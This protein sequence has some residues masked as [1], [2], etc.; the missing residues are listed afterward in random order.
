ML[1]DIDTLSIVL[2]ESF[3]I[4]SFLLAFVFFKKSR[5]IRDKQELLKKTLEKATV[6]DVW[7][8]CYSY[9]WVMSHTLKPRKL[10]EA[11]PFLAIGVFFLTALLFFIFI[12]LLSIGYLALVA[13]I[14]I[15]ILFETDAFEA[16]S[17]SRSLQKAPLDHLKGEDQSY[18]ELAKEALEN[19]IIRFLIIGIIFAIAGPFIP[20]IFDGLIYAFVAYTR[21]MFQTTE[22][23]KWISALALVVALILTGVLLFLPEFAGRIIFR[24]VKL[25]AQRIQ[26][27]WGKR[28]S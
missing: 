4:F 8:S 1:I 15:A 21:I 3:G 12:P 17:Y 2:L 9:K 6:D 13:L 25:L 14:G 7:S 5:K 26:K 27:R 23:S 18:M 24:R 22:A 28:S 11:T 16:Y 19:A 10:L 20:Q